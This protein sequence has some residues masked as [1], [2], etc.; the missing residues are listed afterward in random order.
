MLNVIIN[1]RYLMLS[2]LLLVFLQLSALSSEAVKVT[3]IID[4]DSIS[5]EVQAAG[6][7]LPV[8]VRLQFID[9]PEMRDGDK[10]NPHG[11]R[12]KQALEQFIKAGD[13]VTLWTER[14]SFRSDPHGRVLAVVFPVKQSI[15]AQEHMIKHGHSVYW[16]RFGK[17]PKANDKNWK[18]LELKA[19][20]Q[21]LGLWKH[22]QQWIINKRK[23]NRH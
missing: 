21:S 18:Q 17:M 20:Q 1:M 13:Q 10:E 16:R 3:R 11:V 4:G 5:V 12:A 8:S 19:E 2:C 22:D 14:S 23:E 7:T 9:T 15:S 6:V